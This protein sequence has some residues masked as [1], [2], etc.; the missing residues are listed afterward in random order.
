MGVRAL[1]ALYGSYAHEKTFCGLLWQEATKQCLLI[2]TTHGQLMCAYSSHNR[3]IMSTFS[4]TSEAQMCNKEGQSK[5]EGQ[6]PLPS[7]GATTGT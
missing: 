6:G 3:V 5:T 4:Q 2:K 1:P 7:P